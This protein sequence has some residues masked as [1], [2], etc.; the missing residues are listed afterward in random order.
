VCVRA[1]VHA[2]SVPCCPAH[3]FNVSLRESHRHQS[4]SS[5]R[6]LYSSALQVVGNMRALHQ[7]NQILLWLREYSNLRAFLHF[8][9][10][11]RFTLESCEAELV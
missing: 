2:V 9:A 8:H 6:G 1:C 10:E 7:G 5:Y 3:V 4:K 11:A